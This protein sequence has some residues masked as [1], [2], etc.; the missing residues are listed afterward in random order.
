MSDETTTQAAAPTPDAGAGQTTEQNPDAGGNQAGQPFAV[1]PNAESFNKR[2]DREAR[3]ALDREARAA[4]F[5]NWQA[6]LEHRTQ[7]P[8][9]PA[10]GPAQTPEPETAPAQ[11][12]ATIDEAARLRL[13]IEIGGDLGL[14]PAL[15]A[16]LQ[17]NTREEIQADAE[18]L[19]GAIQQPRGP[20]IPPAPRNNQTVTFT[21]A[22]LQNPAFV[23]EN[24]AAIQQAAR[25]GRIADA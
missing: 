16:R 5:D 15:L 8:A 25:E 17:G 9:A 20:G 19:A 7:P 2:V 10:P 3:Q 13:A 23:R 11:A 22:Q 14:A 21:R 1:F 24:A 18:R 12:P 6:L 4:G